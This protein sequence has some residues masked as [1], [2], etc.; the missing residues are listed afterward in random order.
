[1]VRHRYELFHADVLLVGYFAQPPFAYQRCGR[2]Q[3]ISA[4]SKYSKLA[5][6]QHRVLE[7]DI[8]QR[9][10]FRILLIKRCR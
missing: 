7:R 8:A 4:K 5:L 6:F 10:L 1:M 3:E 2:E 9:M